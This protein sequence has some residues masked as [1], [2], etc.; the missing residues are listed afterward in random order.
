MKFLIADMIFWVDGLNK[1][2][3]ILFAIVPTCLSLG[4]G[5]VFDH[6]NTKQ[7]FKL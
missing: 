3:Q 7:W 5:I 1:I 4:L 6:L 2:Q